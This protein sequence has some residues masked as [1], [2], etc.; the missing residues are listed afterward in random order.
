MNRKKKLIFLCD[1]SRH[2]ICQPYSLQNLLLMATELGISPLWFD[3]DHYDMPKRRI[4]EI[5]KKC[6]IVR[7]KEI[8]QIIKDHNNGQFRKAKR[9]KI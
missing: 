5:S 9:I 6:K 7:S 3:K 4:K 1:K 2:L 8:V